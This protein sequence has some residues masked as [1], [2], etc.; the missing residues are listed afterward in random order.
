MI[1]SLIH[2]LEKINQGRRIYS[3]SLNHQIKVSCVSNDQAFKLSTSHDKKR[4]I[5]SHVLSIKTQHEHLKINIQI[6]SR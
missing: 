1:E 3:H 5:K 2:K 6:Q 4:R